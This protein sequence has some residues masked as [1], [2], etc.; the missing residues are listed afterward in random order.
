MYFTETPHLQ[1][2]EA[3]MKTIPHIRFVVFTSFDICLTLGGG[4]VTA[5]DCDLD[6]FH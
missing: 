2:I 5:D 4:D 3:M 6:I 1:S